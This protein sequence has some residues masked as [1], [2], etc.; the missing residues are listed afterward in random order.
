VSNLSNHS[1]HSYFRRFLAVL[2]FVAGSFAI[3]MQYRWNPDPHHDGIM[4]TAAVGFK[5]GLRP[6]VDFFAQYGPLA[7]VLQGLGLQVFG[8]TLFG[9]RFFSAALLIFT[10]AMFTIR[11]SQVY[12]LKVACLLWMCWSLTGPMGLP[13]SS[14]ITTFLI[15]FVLFV[16]FGYRSQRVFFR[17]HIFLV[18]SQLLLIG[19]M[20]RIH[21]A[22]IVGLIGLTFVVKRSSLPKGFTAKWIWLSLTTALILVFLLH[23]FE[24]LGAYFEQSFVWAISH[25]STPAL[26]L[27]YLSGLIWFAIIPTTV[28]ALCLLLNRFKSF[29]NKFKYPITI[30][31]LAILASF[32][33]YANAYTNRDAESLFDPR[34]FF[35]EFF[36]RFSLMLNYLPVTL[37][38]LAITLLL[39]KK[40][41]LLQPNNLSNLILLSIGLGTLAQLYPLFD[42]WHLWLIS[43]AIIMSL[44]LLRTE[45]RAHAPYSKSLTYISIVV[46][47]ALG[48]NFVEVVKSQTFEFKSLVLNGMTSSRGDA[49]ALDETMLAIEKANLEKQSVRF[50]CGDGLYASASQTYLSQG[51]LFVD[52]NL[53]K[54]TLDSQT[55]LIFVCDY[56]QDAIDQYLKSGWDEIFILPSGHTNQ[57]NERL[58][59]A[60][61]KRE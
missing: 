11:A 21:L 28:F 55:R 9:L 22:V 45:H 14:V 39:F 47:L 4:F 52:W 18:A 41:R 58:S 25:Y 12:G 7:P 19:S 51:P 43:P 10:G 3:I 61:M 35:I 34:Y 60:L 1:L 38:V 24:I 23:E 53:D 31:S 57:K 17:P 27:T 32:L 13:W 6:N 36:R 44:L 48:V 16:S 33:I 30:V 46:A 29:P 49:R 5:E 8:S 26:T 15:V 50:L 2:V 56:T 37:L 20:I 40:Q 54:I 42:P 59:N